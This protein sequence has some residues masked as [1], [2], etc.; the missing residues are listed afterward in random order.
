VVGVASSLFLADLSNV[1]VCVLHR[2]KK[3]DKNKPEM[4]LDQSEDGEREEDLVSLEDEDA[5]PQGDKENSPRK[6]S[7][8]SGASSS[9]DSSPP[10]SRALEPVHTRRVHAGAG[11]GAG[12]GGT[13][14]PQRGRTPL[15]HVGFDG[16]DVSDDSL[17]TE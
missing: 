11:A 16:V 3:G 10:K 6:R 2:Q 15:A 14:R 8:G 5:G 9:S 17:D 12:A 1:C 13:P 4:K 7:R